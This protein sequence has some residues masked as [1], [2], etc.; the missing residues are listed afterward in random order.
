[1]CL[2]VSTSLSPLFASLFTS[3]SYRLM[4]L[5]QVFLRRAVLQRLTTVCLWHKCVIAHL[6]K[7]VVTAGVI[8][9]VGA[10]VSGIM[11]V[12]FGGIIY[13]W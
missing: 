10:F 7:L 5:G 6:L 11:G 13:A 8:L 12:A 9:I 4:I 2:K 1:M 3:C